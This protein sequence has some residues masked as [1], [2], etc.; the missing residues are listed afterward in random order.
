MLEIKFF[1]L[2]YLND[3]YWWDKPFIERL[4]NKDK[5]ERLE[6]LHDAAKFYKVTRNFKKIEES[7]RLELALDHLESFQGPVDSENVNKTVNDLSE[8]LKVE[9]GKHTISASSKFLW[10]RFKSPVIIYDSRAL[11]WLT[12]NGFKPSDDSY[13]SFRESWLKAFCEKEQEIKLSC[14][15]LHTVKEYSHAN[16]ATD[17]EILWLVSE[18]WFHERVFD[19]YLWFY[20]NVG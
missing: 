14:T 17:S 9:Y 6:A 12:T 11:G 19:K 7:N 3:W 13:A 5:S 16:S 18:T 8:A 2:M 10:L 4:R 20:G 1:A 15:D